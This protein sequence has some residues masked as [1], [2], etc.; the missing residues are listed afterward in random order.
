MHNINKGMTDMSSTMSSIRT[1]LQPLKEKKPNPWDVL[2]HISQNPSELAKF[3]FMS[4]PEQ[5]KILFG[6][7]VTDE[8]L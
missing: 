8:E 4:K 5:N 6:R 7:D 2:D 3:K 1:A